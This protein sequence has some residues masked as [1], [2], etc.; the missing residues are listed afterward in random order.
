MSLSDL[1]E[2]PEHR[3]KRILI[4]DDEPFNLMSMMAILRQA[5]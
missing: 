2:G 3:Y 5:A 1:N 4:I